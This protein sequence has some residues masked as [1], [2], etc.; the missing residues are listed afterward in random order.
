M[1]LEKYL[2]EEALIMVPALYVIGM[3]IK[4]LAVLKDKY[5]PAVLLLLSIAFTPAIIGIYNADS[6]VQAI[7]VAGVTV[8]TNQF[9]K[10]NKEEE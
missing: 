2:I 3:V 5:I 4:N 8:F 6:I 7:L 9:I 10:Q 1:E